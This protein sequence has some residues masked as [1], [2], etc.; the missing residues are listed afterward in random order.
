MTD[1]R[2]LT[3]E[4]LVARTVA[5]RNEHTSIVTELIETLRSLVPAFRSGAMS[6][7]NRETS[8]LLNAIETIAEDSDSN[9]LRAALKACREGASMQPG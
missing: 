2:S 5:H 8:M 1:S 6:L 4:E 9:A 7:E 3:G